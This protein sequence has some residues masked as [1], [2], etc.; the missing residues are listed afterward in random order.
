MLR[1][2]SFIASGVETPVNAAL[3][4]AAENNP[5][6]AIA[7]MIS[8]GFG[9]AGH[10]F[11]GPIPG[12]AMMTGGRKVMGINVPQALTT[13]LIA[14]NTYK[15]GALAAANIRTPVQVILGG[16]DRMAPMKAGM[17]LANAL[18]DPQ[19]DIIRGSGHMVPLE[20]PNVCRNL[21]KEFIF[22]NNPAS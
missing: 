18:P 15:N 11:Q 1:S 16:K 14:C 17:K 13:D 3:I 19:L 6:A 20:A 10:L 8:W 7:M 22:S 21:L 2:V 4:D 5:E 12:N 9:P